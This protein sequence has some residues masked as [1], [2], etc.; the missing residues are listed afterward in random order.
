MNMHD[1]AHEIGNNQ[2]EFEEFFKGDKEKDVDLSG[3]N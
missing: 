3:A 1:V 2:L